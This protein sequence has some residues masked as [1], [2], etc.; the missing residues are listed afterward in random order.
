MNGRGRGEGG[1]VGMKGCDNVHYYR[2]HLL[3]VQ[4]ALSEWERAGRRVA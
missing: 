1:D 3:S 4:L 2:T